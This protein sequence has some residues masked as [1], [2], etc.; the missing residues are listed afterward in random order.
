MV[1]ALRHHYS[2]RFF[3]TR[4]GRGYF[5]MCSVNYMPFRFMTEGLVTPTARRSR[6]RAIRA[7]PLPTHPTPYSRNYSYSQRHLLFSKLF[8][9]NRRRATS[10]LKGE[11]E[12]LLFYI[13][14]HS[15]ARIQRILGAASL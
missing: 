14:V 2:I 11:V 3:R 9:N 4:G 1:E 8:P 12:R 5:H 15:R 10:A 13:P 6:V 7:L